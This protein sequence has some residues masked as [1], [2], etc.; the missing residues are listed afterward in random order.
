MSNLKPEATEKTQRV[1]DN[2]FIGLGMTMVIVTSLIALTSNA[3]SLGLLLTTF[4][5]GL[6]LVLHGIKQLVINQIIKLDDK[7]EPY[8]AYRLTRWL[9]VTALTVTVFVISAIFFFL[10]DDDSAPNE[11]KVDHFAGTDS[12]GIWDASDKHYYDQKPP[13]PFF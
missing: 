10:F 7:F 6:L 8:I 3:A 5:V 11:T 9:T 12:D 4:I 2:V 13:P 1:R